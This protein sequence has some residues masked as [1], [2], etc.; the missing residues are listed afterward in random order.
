MARPVAAP[1]FT[2]NNVGSLL[3]AA[4]VLDNQERLGNGVAFKPEDC[5]NGGTLQ[6]CPAEPVEKT[7]T[8]GDGPVTV[9]TYAD[10]FGQVCSTNANPDVFDETVERARRGLEIRRSNKIE[11]ALW[12][13]IGTITDSS[14]LASTAA[15]DINSGVAVGIVP[16]LADMVTALND[17]LGG[18]RGVIHMTQDLAAAYQNFYGLVVR[19]GNMLQVANTDHVVVAGTGYP[20]TDPDGNTPPAGETWIYGTGPVN[21][22]MSSID[23]V[24]PFA[25]QSIDRSTNS[26]EVRAEFAFAAYFNPCAHIAVAVCTPDPGPECGAS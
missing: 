24:A 2:P 8:A 14:A 25:G 9:P 6:L 26:V 13:G 11:A 17:V 19:N 20:G 1:Q 21:V 3:S 10:W 22:L 4:N 5:T 16:A 7:I 15:D 18:A 12:S 23:I